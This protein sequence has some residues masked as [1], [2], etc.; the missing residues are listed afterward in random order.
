MLNQSLY[1]RL[2]GSPGIN[3]LVD[4]IVAR[5]MEN[6]VIR[7]RFQPYL[8][9][10]DRLKITKQHLCA[11]LEAGSGGS[12]KYTGRDMKQ[13]HRG[14]NINEAEYMAALD[15]ILDALRKRGI[16]EQTQKD[17]LAIAYSLKGDI[18]H[19]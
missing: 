9:T 3:A 5:H 18:L 16:D 11:F 19:M 4:D 13:A 10:P 2:G 8:E 15:D 14:M 7:S 17:V 1:E 12:A 6:P